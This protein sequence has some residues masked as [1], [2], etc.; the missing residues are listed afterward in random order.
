MYFPP[1]GVVPDWQP[2]PGTFRPQRRVNEILDAIQVAC[3]RPWLPSVNWA[4]LIRKIRRREMEQMFFT[5]PPE[6][7]NGRALVWEDPPPV[8]ED[9]MRWGGT[10]SDPLVMHYTDVRLV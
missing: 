5:P 3:D 10:W 6:W 4:R 2:S 8:W 7:L 9:P 1:F